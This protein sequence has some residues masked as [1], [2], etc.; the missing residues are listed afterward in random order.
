VAVNE[1]LSAGL[2]KWAKSR[3]TMVVSLPATAPTT[4]FFARLATS[5]PD[6]LRLYTFDSPESILTKEK[7][8]P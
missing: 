2:W 5:E 4:I 3:Q 6:K 7:E 1:N 8:A